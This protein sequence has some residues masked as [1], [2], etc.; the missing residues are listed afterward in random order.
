MLVV[1]ALLLAA[2]TGDDGSD[3]TTGVLT[4]TATPEEVLADEVVVIEVAGAPPGA[5]VGIEVAS[6][7]DAGVAWSSTT[8]VPADTRGRVVLDDEPMAPFTILTPAD[9]TSDLAYIWGPDGNAFEV[10]A[11][12]GS[13]EPARVEVR[14]RLL[15]EGVTPASTTLEDDGVAGQLF[16]P[17]PGTAVGS[18]VVL[19]GGSDGGL[20]AQ[21][22]DGFALASRGVTALQVAYFGLPGLPA[23]L[24][25]IPLETFVTAIERLR[26][27]PDVDPERIWLVG[28]SRGSEA[29]ALVAARHPDLVAGVA[30]TA[31]GST[32]RCSVDDRARA[33]W[34]EGGAPIPCDPETPLPVEE[35]DG[36][37]IA[38]CGGDDA[39]WAACPQAEDLFDRLAAEDR[40]PG[41][42]LVSDPTA[43]HLVG[44]LTPYVWPTSTT[45]TEGLPM[46]GNPRADDRVRAEA[47]PLILEALGA[48]AP[49]R[50]RHGRAPLRC[51]SVPRTGPQAPMTSMPRK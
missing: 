1:V 42:H 11:R 38:T 50:T 17:A 18:G 49:E 12:A 46:G 45:R 36:P 27:E 44:L 34:T 35:V 31:T 15:A 26:E 33:A 41:D 10:T 48:D 25:D 5:Q 24:A 47:W 40:P 28:T 23:E 6:T 39:L 19:I 3:G 20:G 22:L 14:R 9:E 16:S 51:T 32:V 37:V 30:L 13:R 4:V 2:C 21:L 8:T 7:D 43:G 29:A